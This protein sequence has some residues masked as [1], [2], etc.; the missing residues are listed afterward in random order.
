MRKTRNLP[1]VAPLSNVQHH[2]DRPK[3]TLIRLKGD[4]R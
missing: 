4:L 3:K 2:R 1:T